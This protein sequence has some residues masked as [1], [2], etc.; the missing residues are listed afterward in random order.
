[1]P[2]LEPDENSAYSLASVDIAGEH[3]R[4]AMGAGPAPP[5]VPRLP[6]YVG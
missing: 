4:Q 2:A 6:S 3:G 1:M 5:H